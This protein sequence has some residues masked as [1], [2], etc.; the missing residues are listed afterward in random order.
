MS[1]LI[2]NKHGEH[3]ATNRTPPPRNPA[4]A[5]SQKQRLGVSGSTIWNWYKNG[6]FPKLIKLSENCI[7]WHAT[8]AEAWA[9][10]RIAASLPDHA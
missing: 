6:T 1:N 4:V 3:Y 8:D 10:A 9:Q 7:T 5:I 2:R